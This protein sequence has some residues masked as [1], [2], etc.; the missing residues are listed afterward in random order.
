ML[1]QP[2]AQFRETSPEHCSRSPSGSAT[3]GASGTPQHALLLPDGKPRLLRPRRTD[4]R[5]V[6]RILQRDSRRLPHRAGHFALRTPRGRAIPQHGRGVRRGR[7]HSREIPEDAHPR[8][9]RLL[10]EVLLHPRRHRL[11][12][13]TDL[14]WETRRAG[15]LGPVVSRGSA[16][17]GLKGRRTAHLPYRH[18]MGKHRCAGRENAPIRGMDHRAARTCRGQR[19]AR[20][21][22][23]PR[24]VRA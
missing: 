14:H 5:P 1:R 20:D 18:R 16:A 21:F 11:R 6:D 17:D 24:R 19:T 13:H 8:R 7:E 15:V 22:G 3:G 9:P 12:T 10:R 23:E 2:Q 4:T